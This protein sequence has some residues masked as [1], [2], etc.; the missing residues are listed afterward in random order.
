M[1]P[2]A[3]VRPL[4]P[5]WEGVLDAVLGRLPGRFSTREVG[6]LGPRVEALSRAYNA[7]EAEGRRTKL[8][9]EARVAFSFPRDV[10]KGAAAVR[11]L[12]RQYSELKHEA[13]GTWKFEPR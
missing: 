12:V 5:R 4:E 3:L 8:P 7:G 1:D 11:E 13:K 2:R 10:P 6:R 9:V